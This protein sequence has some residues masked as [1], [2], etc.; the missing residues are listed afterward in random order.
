MGDSNVGTNRALLLFVVTD[1][2]KDFPDK[3]VVR[4][5]NVM[6]GEC[7]ATSYYE[8]YDTIQQVREKM[9]MH[10]LIRLPRHPEDDPVIVETWI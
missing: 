4:M 3:F 6:S 9:S 10:G 1:H 7:A 8:T 5:F 2:P